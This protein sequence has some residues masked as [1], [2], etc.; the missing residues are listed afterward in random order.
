MIIFNVIILVVIL[1]ERE[2]DYK[3]SENEV[4]FNNILFD[5]IMFT[6]S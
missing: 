2:N 6:E 1:K 3:D 5:N 4:N